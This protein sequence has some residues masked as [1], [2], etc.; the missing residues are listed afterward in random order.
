[1]ENKLTDDWFWTATY[2][3]F[4]VSNSHSAN[5]HTATPLLKPKHEHEMC[6]KTYPG[7]SRIK[8]FPEASQFFKVQKEICIF[9]PLYPF[10]FLWGKEWFTKIWFK[11]FF[12]LFCVGDGADS[13]L[14]FHLH[15]VATK[16]Q[17]SFCSLVLS[18]VRK[19][20]NFLLS[21]Y[22]EFLF[23]KSFSRPPFTFKAFKRFLSNLIRKSLSDAA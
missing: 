13:S 18:F 12:C 17:I 11:F 21:S 1:M 4:G 9:G 22:S 14:T 15:P 3:L 6:C 20:F 16:K 8:S 10:S 19:K 5:C 23:L 7:L 2:L